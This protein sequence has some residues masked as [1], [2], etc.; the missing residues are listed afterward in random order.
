MKKIIV[1]LTLVSALVIAGGCS[2]TPEDP[3]INPEP[4]VDISTPEE[5]PENTPPGE[6]DY[7]ESKFSVVPVNY[8]TQLVVEEF[9]HEGDPFTALYVVKDGL[10]TDGEYQ[11]T[12]NSS[13]K[14][15]TE[16]EF[17][18]YLG[19]NITPDGLIV[20]QSSDGKNGV[21]D[22]NGTWIIEPQHNLQILGD[23]ETY[24]RFFLG[25]IEKDGSTEGYVLYNAKGDIIQEYDN[26]I[27][28]P[29][30][31][32][33]SYHL[34][35]LDGKLI[36]QNGEFIT[37]EEKEGVSVT[38]SAYGQRLSFTEKDKMVSYFDSF[39][40][41]PFDLKEYYDVRY[42]ASKE[43]H[44]RL[45]RVEEGTR[46][47]FPIN[48][49]HLDVYYKNNIVGE[50]I[51]SDDRIFNIEFR[52]DGLIADHN[53]GTLYKINSAGNALETVAQ[54]AEI[55]R[56]EGTPLIHTG[57]EYITVRK[58]DGQKNIGPDMLIDTK[59]NIFIDED[60]GLTNLNS[61]T[62]VATNAYGETVY[63]N[64][65]EKTAITDTQVLEL[66]YSYLNLY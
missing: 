62:G 46:D 10:V 17:Y 49:L 47:G 51:T 66:V 57:N 11:V 58:S 45:N 39:E 56:L 6:R 42:H 5:T 29:M 12:D 9:E 43:M 14:L 33:S 64:P 38:S 24:G 54:F 20:L 59:G 44:T 41:V 1:L 19:N 18:P 48:N 26:T 16:G 52:P 8:N 28:V 22:L 15:L 55:E 35:Y 32:P 27:R 50:L 65:L 61:Q 21:M 37:I 30:F 13:V 63:L 53:T 34:V 4:P 3:G 36:D 2:K 31:I 40:P 7:M 23:R 25:S 60:M